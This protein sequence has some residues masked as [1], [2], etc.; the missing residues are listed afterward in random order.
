MRKFKKRVV[1]EALRK[2]TFLDVTEDNKRVKRKIPLQGLT[3]IDEEWYTR[4]DDP[5]IAYDPRSAKKPAQFPVPLLPQKKEVHP[6]GIS[7]N[8]LKPTGF[9]E[10]YIE[11]LLK[12]EEAQEEMA[13]YDSDKPFAERIEIA[14]QRFK[15]KRRMREMYSKVFTK[16]MLFGGVEQ[17][18]RMFGSLSKQEMA[19]MNAEDIARSLATHRV[20][21][22]RQDTKYWVVDFVGVGEAFL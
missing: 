17:L 19:D 15:L 11:P 8:M 9:E 2:S 21:W 22:D 16:W 5:E 3:A 7:K 18:P 20:P 4:E 14:I 13:L 10:T 1:V 6:P 12:P